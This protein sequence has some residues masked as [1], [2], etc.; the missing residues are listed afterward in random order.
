MAQNLYFLPELLQV[1]FIKS[2]K[3]WVILV[4]K[5]KS[6]TKNKSLIY[7]YNG[8]MPFLFIKQFSKLLFLIISVSNNLFQLV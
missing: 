3:I 5:F 1:I 2:D 6:H 8:I 7:E 4:D